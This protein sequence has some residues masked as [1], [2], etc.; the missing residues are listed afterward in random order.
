MGKQ[1]L[2]YL[3]GQTVFLGPALLAFSFI[4]AI[5]LVMGLYYSFTDWN[6]VSREIRWVGLSNYVFVL[7]QDNQFAA[8]FLFTGKLSFAIVVL[9][10]LL[11]FGFAYVLSHS[12]RTR[13]VLRAAFFLPNVLG[14]LLLGFIWNFIFTKGF[15]SIGQLT[16]WSFFKLSWLGTEA[17]S[18]WALVIVSV[19]Q[20]TGYL[21]VIYIAGL[22]GIPKELREAAVLDGA[23]KWKELRFII[24]PLVIPTLTVCV[25][26]T[27]VWSFRIYDLNFS[28]TGGGP[29]QSTE[30][31][32]MNI[33]T[34][35]FTDNNYGLGSAKA[36]IF[37][38]SVALISL[39]QVLL[40]K[41]AE[42]AFT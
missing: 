31:V 10:N 29:F 41:K 11:G 3:A 8:S 4:V 19:W 36:M 7:L 42:D 9:A 39:I 1:T 37:F 24:L 27:L 22:T 15:V 40:A 17:T 30:S 14:G 13:L 12:L 35:A 28:L 38:V 26:L 5:P 23:G 32:T 18:F 34:D 2:R 33:F 21:M 25:C 16:G 6:G 20:Q